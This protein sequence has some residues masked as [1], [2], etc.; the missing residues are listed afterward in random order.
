MEQQT[1]SSKDSNF[2]LLTTFLWIGV[3]IIVS[4]FSFLAG[5]NSSSTAIN[6][7]PIPSGT[8]V[9]KHPTIAQTTP[10]PSVDLTGICQKTGPSQ[11]KDYLVPY[12]IKVGDSIT[13]I[14]ETQLG[15]KS[16]NTELTILNDNLQNLVVDS[17]FY[18]PPTTIKQSSGHLA[19][20]SGKI[21]KK[22][23]ASWQISYG[24]GAAGPGILIPG[25]WFKDVA[26][27][28]AY[29]IGDCVT[30]FLDNGVKVYSVKKS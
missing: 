29:Q 24:G 25:F 14:A 3:I 26:A 9:S 17:V 5:K 1:S 12:T 2:N 6:N 4:V 7:A 8:A 19:E 11:K 20:V 27:K 28:D 13:S 23:D 21:V 22:D 16:R 18:L 30:I 10:T 15:D